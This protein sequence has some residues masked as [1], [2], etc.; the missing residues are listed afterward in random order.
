ME[1][2]GEDVGPAPVSVDLEPEFA[3][4]VDEAGGDVQQPVA[5]CF[6]LGSRER[7]VV[8]QQD[9]LHPGE[10]VDRGQGAG[11]PRLVDREQL[12]WE[13]AQPGVLAGADAVFDA[14]VAAVPG[15]EPGVLPGT[16]V[17][18]EAGVAP[19]VA[20]FDQVQLG[21]GCGRSRRTMI[22]IPGG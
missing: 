1:G 19:A 9:G 14:G 13:A 12:R 21:T 15:V 2:G 10:Q 17:G 8:V 3:S 18:G 11:Q 5:Q 7:R 20:F 4:A 16:G 6:R 22:R